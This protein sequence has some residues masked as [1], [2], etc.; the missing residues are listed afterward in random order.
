MNTDTLVSEAFRGAASAGA[1]TGKLYL[2]DLVIRPCQACPI[3]P[4]DGYCVIHDGMDS[5]YRVLEDADALVI[6]TPAYYETISAQ[7]KLVVDRSSC[8]T[9][10]VKGADGRIVFRPR[11]SKVKPALFVWVSGSTRNPEHALASLRSWFG[12]ARIELRDQLIATDSDRGEGAR[13]RKELLE[14]ASAK[15]SRLAEAVLARIGT[16][17]TSAPK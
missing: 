12:D 14:Q 15:G 6:G 9:E 4:E 16:S 11:L 3:P 5:V 17:G 7:L 13:G 2:D 8:L 1:Q 10:M